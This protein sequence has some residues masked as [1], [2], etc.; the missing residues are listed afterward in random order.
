MRVSP[1]EV[2]SN[3]SVINCLCPVLVSVPSLN[4]SLKVSSIVN[5]FH[6]LLTI[7]SLSVLLSVLKFTVSPVQTVSQPSQTALVN[8]VWGSKDP[9]DL[10]A[11]AI[12]SAKLPSLWIILA[13]NL[14]VSTHVSDAGLKSRDACQKL[15]IKG[16]TL[17]DLV[18]NGWLKYE[19]SS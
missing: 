2:I 10:S 16:V 14:T 11:S 8:P 1:C 15:S 7:C 18:P 6:T 9:K 3:C 12:V 4:V 5:I 13:S 19:V 17:S